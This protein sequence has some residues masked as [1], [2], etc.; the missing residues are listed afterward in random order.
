MKKNCKNSLSWKL[1][2]CEF[3][4]FPIHFLVGWSGPEIKCTVVHVALA[5]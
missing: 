2:Y 5:K 3:Y 4:P 1:G